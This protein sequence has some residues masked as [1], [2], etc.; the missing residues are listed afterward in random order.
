MAPDRP[1]HGVFGRLAGRLQQIARTQP[2]SLLLLPLALPVLCVMGTAYLIG[3]ASAGLWQ[4][5]G[6]PDTSARAA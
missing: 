1:G 4:P 5:R 2:S 3:R 6:L